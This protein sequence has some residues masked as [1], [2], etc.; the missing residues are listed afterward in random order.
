MILTISPNTKLNT[1]YIAE[2]HLLE[3]ETLG[4]IDDSTNE[5]YN[6]FRYGNRI[7]TGT[8]VYGTVLVMHDGKLHFVEGSDV[9]NSLD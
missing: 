6:T 8:F 2:Y 7:F 9:F 1:D 4:I 3:A 5:T